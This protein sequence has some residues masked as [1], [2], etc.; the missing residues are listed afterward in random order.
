MVFRESKYLFFCSE[1][2]ETARFLDLPLNDRE[3]LG[4]SR[5]FLSGAGDPLLQ[6]QQFPILLYFGSTYAYSSFLHLFAINQKSLQSCLVGVVLTFQWRSQQCTHT[7]IRHAIILQIVA[8]KDSINGIWKFEHFKS[9]PAS[10]QARE[11]A[12]TAATTHA[13]VTNARKSS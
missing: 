1:P 8:L 9:V 6:Q 2:V 3:N 7:F 12:F 11:I 13:K 5:L 4:K 10:T